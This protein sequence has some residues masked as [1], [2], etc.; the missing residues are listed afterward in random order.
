MSHLPTACCSPQILTILLNTD[1]FSFPFTLWAL[2]FHSESENKHLSHS[3][4]YLDSFSLFSGTESLGSFTYCYKGRE[5]PPSP[6]PPKITL[7]ERF[8]I[9]FFSLDVFTTLIEF[10]LLP[11][12][13][14]LPPNTLERASL[15]IFYYVRKQFYAT[16][17]RRMLVQCYIS[18]HA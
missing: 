10:L 2:T 11:L 12:V 14:L 9:I 8:M 6:T 17:G 1:H 7:H 15:C 18:S 5:F 16:D 4:G 3:L 13:A